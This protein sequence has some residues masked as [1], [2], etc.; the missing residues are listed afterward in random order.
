MT[1]RM[2]AAAAAASG[3][4]IVVLLAAATPFASGGNN[5]GTVK[6]H[7]DATESPPTR[8]VPHVSCDFWVEGFKMAGDAGT[9]VFT[10]WP[11]TGD[12]SEVLNAT[13]SADSGNAGKGFHFLA[14]PFNLSADGHYRVEA[15]LDQGHPGNDDHFAKTKTFWV[16]TCGG[17]G[18]NQGGPACP[19]DTTA[20]AQ[21]DGSIQLSWAAVAGATSYIVERATG[22]NDFEEI[23]TT[24]ATTFV[25]TNTEVGVTYDYVITAVSG[26]QA[27]AGCVAIESTAIPF[28]PSAMGMGVAT[29]G[30]VA[31]YA[32]L[33]RRQP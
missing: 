4:A 24:Q 29:V 20:L 28:F 16:E 12:K 21:K 27:S 19:D 11:P 8:N 2:L 10:S 18:N 5:Q 17:G 25:D 14:G 22:N 30:A 31:G 7:D 26:D 3:V 23:G 15:F 1:R 9:L 6:V 33:R 32:V 13:W